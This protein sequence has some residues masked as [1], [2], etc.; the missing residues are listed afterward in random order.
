MSR[1]RLWAFAVSFFAIALTIEAWSQ[2]AAVAFI[3]LGV[4]VDIY[5]A[6]KNR[7]TSGP[8]SISTEC[9]RCGAILQS[10]VGIPDRTCVK[11]GQRQSWA[12]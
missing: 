11:C 7:P 9:Q 3:A 5:V 6:L 4:S 12:R 8:F 2:A 1:N 10:R